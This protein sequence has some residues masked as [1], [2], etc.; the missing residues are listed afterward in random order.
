MRL[1]AA[2][3]KKSCSKDIGKKRKI[4]RCQCFKTYFVLVTDAPIAYAEMLSLASLSV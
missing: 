1:K 4:F 2:V 3:Q